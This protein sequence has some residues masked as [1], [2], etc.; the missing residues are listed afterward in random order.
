MSEKNIVITDCDNTPLARVGANYQ[1]ETLALAASAPDRVVKAGTLMARTIATG[2]TAV[3]VK[4]G[5]PVVNGVAF[6]VLAADVCDDAGAGGDFPCRPLVTG[7][8]TAS[9]LIIDADG[10]NSNIEA[11]EVDSLR[12]FSILVVQTTQLAKLDNPQ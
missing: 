9:Q 6:A 5:D 2:K 1:D 11:V 3:Y 4:G 7:E 12:D 8:V 10:D